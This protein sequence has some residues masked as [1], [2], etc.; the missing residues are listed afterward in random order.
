MQENQPPRLLTKLE[1]ARALRV[2]Q[3]TI[4]QWVR[5]GRIP[6]LTMQRTV[7]FDFEA[8]KQAMSQPAKQKSS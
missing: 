1:L 4:M 6:K 8:V 7:R 3:N 5:D 2:S